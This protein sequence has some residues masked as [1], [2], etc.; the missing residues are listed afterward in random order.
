MA[1]LI[2][3]GSALAPFAAKLADLIPDP[4]AKA[5]AAAQMQI[6]QEQLQVQLD[7]AQLAVN[8]AEAANKAVFVSGWRPFIGW[9]CGASFAWSYVLLP[10]G[11]F[12]CAAAGHPITLPKVD[13]A[14]VMQIMLM[15]LGGGVASLR[16][17]EKM[18]GIASGNQAH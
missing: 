11:T 6:A 15:M 1:G 7:Q 2:D 18:Q 3:I 12:A 4:A 13:D 17:F 14:D 16:T 10:L 5:A 8:Q 9:V